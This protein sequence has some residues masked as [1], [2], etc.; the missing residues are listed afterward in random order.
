M[1]IGAYEPTDTEC[2]WPSEDEDDELA[3]EIKD[4][5]REQVQ[6]NYFLLWHHKCEC[7]LYFHFSLLNHDFNVRWE[8]KI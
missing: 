6:S 2:D 4:K 1:T 3:D 5:V 7:I 8:C